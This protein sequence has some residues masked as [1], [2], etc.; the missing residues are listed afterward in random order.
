MTSD[1]DARDIERQCWKCDE[2]VPT[3]NDLSMHMRIVHGP[4]VIG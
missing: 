4:V 1:T 3:G 2:V